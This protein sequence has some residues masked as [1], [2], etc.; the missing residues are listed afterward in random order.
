MVTPGTSNCQIF[1]NIETTYEHHWVVVNW[2]CLELCTAYVQES[3]SSIRSYGKIL[4]RLLPY[5]WTNHI[6][7]H[8]IN[9]ICY[10]TISPAHLFSHATMCE[11]VFSL[12][13]T[14]ASQSMHA[15]CIIKKFFVIGWPECCKCMF[16]N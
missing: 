13:H 9:I 5:F 15:L 16:Q 10:N 8:V 2:D 11:S 3:F 14:N 12:S 1:C 6:Y 7:T 4:R